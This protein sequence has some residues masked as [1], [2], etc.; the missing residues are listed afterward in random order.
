MLYI[1]VLESSLV[2]FCS[3][4]EIFWSG[5]IEDET[6]TTTVK[7]KY[8]SHKYVSHVSSKIS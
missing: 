3:G 4:T 7:Q 5:W 8:V 2:Y 6:E 1:L